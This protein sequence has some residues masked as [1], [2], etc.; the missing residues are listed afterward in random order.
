ME[1]ELGAFD[2]VVVGGGTAGCLLANR[3]SRD[4]SVSVALIEAGGSDA[5]LW[6]RIPVGY[7]FCIGNPRTDWCFLT[8]PEPGLLGRAIRYPRGRVLG[9][10]SSINGMI[11]MRG[12]RE[13]YDAWRDGDGFGPN[14][15][16]SW[17]EVLPLFKQHEDYHGGTDAWH[18][19]GG[20]WRVERQRVRWDV[21]DAFRAAAAES[22]IPPIEDFNRGDNLGCGYFEV[23]QRRGVRW[24]AAQAFLRPIRRRPNLA[25][26]SETQVRRL[27]VQAGRCTGVEVERE[28]Q[29]AFVAARGEVVLA[30]GAIGSPH[31]LQLSG[32][33]PPES[34]RPHGI[35]VSHEL[36]GVGANLQDHLQLRCAYRVSG[37]RTLNTLAATGLGRAGMALQYALTRSG[38]LTM[39]PSQLGAFACS[40]RE[41]A[42]PNLEFHVQPLSLDSFG[43]PLHRF[44][45]F[46]VSV[47]NLRPTA[48]GTVRLRSADP[49]V[50]PAIAPS[51]L[52]TPEDRAVAADSLRL[53]RAIVAA[54][55]LQPLRPEEFR[56]GL[57]YMSGEELVQ[58]AGVV[59]TT[60]F[61]PVGTCKMGPARDPMAV[62]DAQLRVHGVAG[63]RVIDASVM[64]AIT[65]G[66]TNA[67]TLMIAEKGAQAVIDARR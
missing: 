58:A 40:S 2:Y 32:I 37:V 29:P 41:V 10:C 67:P 38:P 43:E 11:Y 39:S 31:L 44:D 7:L 12:Q 30:A 16:W 23:N 24:N 14:P 61:H 34:L 19:S 35:A 59:G 52:T 50:P 57:E 8:E 64:P 27:R 49:G 18:G 21:L 60:I 25:L 48:R 56:P 1:K 45:A 5:Q 4:P 9:G 54:P 51:Y 22:G 42:R 28:G 62:V 6:V 66:N 33:G 36:P 26:F 20:E 63:L 55:A 13:D 17:D 46:T 65:S 53:V 3:L 47:C 15:G